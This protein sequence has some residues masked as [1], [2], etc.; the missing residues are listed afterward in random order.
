MIKRT[1]RPTSN[2]YCLNNAIVSDKDLSWAA[3]GLLVFLLTKPD[4]WR[5]S[6][7]HLIA[8]TKLALGKKS[9]RDNVYSLLNELICAGYISRKEVRDESGKIQESDYII[10]EVKSKNENSASTIIGN[11]NQ[12]ETPTPNSNLGDK[13]ISNR[14]VI[15]QDPHTEKP[16]TANPDSAKQTLTK[17]KVKKRIKKELLPT[18]TD[19]TITHSVCSG[20]Y[21]FKPDSLEI[22]LGIMSKT[23]SDAVKQY[24]S[25][26]LDDLGT[27]QVVLDEVVGKIRAAKALGHEKPIKT[28][29]GYTSTIVS[30]L[31]QGGFVESH[32]ISERKRRENHRLNELTKLA[33]VNAS[34]TP[35]DPVVIG[36]PFSR[37]NEELS[38]SEMAMSQIFSM[39]GIKKPLNTVNHPIY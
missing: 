13:P 12:L 29:V 33:Y 39:I 31:K 36:K 27:A 16:Y 15:T 6:L 37:T 11:S 7:A 24:L 28:I 8:E 30:R 9:G 20:S 17:N 10:S 19:R 35:S 22:E 2:F 34:P 5:I 21:S 4:N 3:R 25:K 1:S 26:S 14:S 32:S 38:V 18:Q 23:E